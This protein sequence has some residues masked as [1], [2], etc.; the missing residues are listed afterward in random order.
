MYE[1]QRAFRDPENAIKVFWRAHGG[2]EVPIHVKVVRVSIDETERLLV[3]SAN[4]GFEIVV[5]AVKV[6]E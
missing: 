5:E 3:K 4:S 6:H 1:R 2:R